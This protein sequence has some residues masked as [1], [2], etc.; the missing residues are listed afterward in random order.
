MVLPEGSAY[1]D[2]MDLSYYRAK[3][4]AAFLR[5]ECG[6]DERLLFV[7]ARGDTEPLEGRDFSVAAQTAN[8]RVE[9]IMTEV[10]LEEMSPDAGSTDAA[11][12]RGDSV[13]G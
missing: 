9:V 13:D 8:R 12:A 3:N 2:L 5:D 10:V 4:T 7:E 6:I 1:A 11:S